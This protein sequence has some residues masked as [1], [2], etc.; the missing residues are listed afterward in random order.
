[1]EEKD[2]LPTEWKDILTLTRDLLYY[3]L[4]QLEERT[5]L[6]PRLKPLMKSKGAQLKKSTE[7]LFLCTW[8]LFKV[9]RV[10]SSD[11]ISHQDHTHT[12]KSYFLIGFLKGG[13]GKGRGWL[14]GVI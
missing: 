3:L 5:N 9:P 11:T 8:L 2:F 14:F 4:L 10:R 12:H 1:M 6:I 13:K 7:S